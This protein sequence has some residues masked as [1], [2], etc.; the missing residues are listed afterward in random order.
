[1][2]ENVAVTNVTI[3]VVDHTINTEELDRHR[4]AWPY[5]MCTFGPQSQTLTTQGWVVRLKAEVLGWVHLSRRHTG[6]DLETKW[7]S[8]AHWT[9]AVRPVII[10]HQMSGQSIFIPGVFYED[11]K[12][13]CD[14]YWSYLNSIFCMALFCWM[15]NDKSLLGRSLC[16]GHV[17]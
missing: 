10:P 12:I 7:S 5:S 1:M 15:L 11:V 17:V 8:T 13:S 6:N 9:T 14:L 16:C 3:N 2:D 4:Q